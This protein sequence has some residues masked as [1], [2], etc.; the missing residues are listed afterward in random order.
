MSWFEYLTIALIL[1]G[2]GIMLY[3]IVFTRKILVVVHTLKIQKT[4]VLLI[5]L[6]S[7]FFVGYLIAAGLVISENKNLVVLITGFI[8]CFGAVF[9][10]I[11]VH[12][13]Y[14]TIMAIRKLYKTSEQAE[15]LKKAQVELINMNNQLLYKNRELGQFAY[16]ASHDLQEPL[17]TMHSFTQLLEE[18]YK[19]KLD[20]D[21]DKYIRFI[22]EASTRMSEQIKGLLDYSKIGSEKQLDLVDCNEVANL[23]LGDLDSVIKES[24]AKIQIDK[25]PTLNAYPTELKQLF[26][27]L[28][29]NAIKYRKKDQDP[30]INIAALREDGHWKFSFADNGIGI[31]DQHKEKIFILF[32]RLHG[33]A[34]YEGEGIGLA[35]CKKIIELHGGKLWVNSQ[36]NQGSTFYFT[37]PTNLQ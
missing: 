31:E 33:R 36:Y 23:L 2:A 7:I 8:F 37:I 13:G 32:K 35:Q 22:S 27:N 28:I 12:T 1:I 21:A 9:V 24:K 11:T 4:W 14:S 34:E 30:L 15:E 10:A 16:I 29:T 25:L 20:E 5:V 3:A 18:Q 6:M 19:G 26:H 17:R